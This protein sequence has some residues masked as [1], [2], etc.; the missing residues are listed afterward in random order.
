[1][2]RVY[3]LS[4][5]DIKAACAAW[6]QKE[7]GDGKPPSEYEVVLNH[8]PGDGPHPAVVTATVREK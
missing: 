1:V 6:V 8:H 7:G 4:Q 3:E 5:N 2:R